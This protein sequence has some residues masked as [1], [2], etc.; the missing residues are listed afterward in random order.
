MVV[1]GQAG[2]RAI[3]CH[4][5]RCQAVSAFSKTMVERERPLMPIQQPVCD[6][7]DSG[8]PFG[9]CEFCRSPRLPAPEQRAAW[10]AD[11]LIQEFGSMH[12]IS[13]EIAKVLP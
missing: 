12:P 6:L 2:F 7:L 8:A 11:Q 9:L 4:S 3:T 10:F 13:A 1:N 5:C